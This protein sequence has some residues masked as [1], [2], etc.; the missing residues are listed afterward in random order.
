[1]KIEASL[2]EYEC[3]VVEKETDGVPMLDDRKQKDQE[4]GEGI[5]YLL[6][7]APNFSKLKKTTDTH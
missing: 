4:S 1:M 7:R 2:I 5:L 6:F 3:Q